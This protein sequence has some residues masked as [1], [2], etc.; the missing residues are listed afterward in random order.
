MCTRTHTFWCE[1]LIF[2]DIFCFL[3]HRA[4]GSVNLL[5]TDVVNVCEARFLLRSDTE[6]K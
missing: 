6:R 2:D 3:Y 4:E 5:V 1:L